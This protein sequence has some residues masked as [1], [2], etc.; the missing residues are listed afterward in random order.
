M[1]VAVLERETETVNEWNH[2]CTSQC[3]NPC[4]SSSALDTDLAPEM[5]GTRS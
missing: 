1:A 2:S 5:T 3:P 4:P